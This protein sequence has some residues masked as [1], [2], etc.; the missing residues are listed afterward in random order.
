MVESK[1]KWRKRLNGFTSQRKTSE[2]SNKSKRERERKWIR[3]SSRLGGKE[4]LLGSAA[5]AW[6]ESGLKFS[7]TSPCSHTPSDY[8]HVGSQN[9]PPA[10]PTKPSAPGT[11]QSESPGIWVT[12]LART[13]PHQHVGVST[14]AMFHTHPVPPLHIHAVPLPWVAQF[15]RGWCFSW[16]IDNPSYVIFWD[17][18]WWSYR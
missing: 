14:H 1:V 17:L 18:Q 6:W 12:C 15:W 9:H 2:Q 16:V 8:Q 13:W 7:I 11:D 10:L 4:L 3:N 5:R